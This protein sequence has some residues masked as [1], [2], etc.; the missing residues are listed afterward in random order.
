MVVE[1]F[2]NEFVIGIATSAE[3]R[4][5]ADY[6]PSL[7]FTPDDYAEGALVE[8]PRFVAGDISTAQVRM[9]NRTIHPPV[10]ATAQAMTSGNG[11]CTDMRS[12][13]RTPVGR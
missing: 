3:Q 7:D 5:L 12:T 6:D 2:A 8:T 4:N 9:P 11:H 1:K 13:P 10:G